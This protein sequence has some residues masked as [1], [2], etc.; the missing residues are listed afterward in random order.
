MTKF[1]DLLD[2]KVS[3]YPPFIIPVDSLCEMGEINEKE[4]TAYVKCRRLAED[5][6][7]IR[8]AIEHGQNARRVAV[9]YPYMD[10]DNGWWM[11]KVWTR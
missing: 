7:I 8:F 4:C 6:D 2:G 9:G 5:R 1:Q 10:V 11:Y 3:E